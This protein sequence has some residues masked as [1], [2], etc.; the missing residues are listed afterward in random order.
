MDP[1]YISL[2]QEWVKLDNIILRNST[3]VKRAKDEVKVIEERVTD[4]IEKKK[5]IEDEIIEY[6]QTNKLE[7]M[8]LKISDGV[9]TFGK[10]TTQKPMSQKFIREILQ[11]YSEE[12]PEE[13]LKHAKLFEYITSNIDKKV[14]YSINRNVK[15][16]K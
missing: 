3:D 14:E 7:T 9:I 16:A 4:V 5:K 15:G 10:K 6:V 12:H 11:K 2:V 1:H 13:N 8:Q